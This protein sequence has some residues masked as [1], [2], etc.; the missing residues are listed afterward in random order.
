M[1][2]RAPKTKM[3]LTPIAVA[4]DISSTFA[5]NPTADNKIANSID[6]VRTYPNA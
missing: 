3:Q 5:T 4:S 2:R 6:P 1:Q